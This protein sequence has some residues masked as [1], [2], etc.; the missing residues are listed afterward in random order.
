MRVFLALVLAA[1]I[2]LGHDFHD[3]KIGRVDR[4]LAAAH[5]KHRHQRGSVDESAVES[6]EGGEQWGAKGS[7][8][9]ERLAGRV[10]DRAHSALT[11]RGV[12]EEFATKAADFAK[13]KAASLGGRA[14]ERF[15][16]A[17]ESSKARN[18]KLARV[19]GAARKVK[20]FAAGPQ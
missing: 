7:Q 12:P 16:A 18:G 11:S 2:V 15:A 20:S 5:G 17:Y 9:G 13:S 3:Y 14:G 1:T 8:H 10:A 4:S 6:D 19:V